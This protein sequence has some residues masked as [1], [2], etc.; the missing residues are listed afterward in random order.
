MMTE[1]ELD[2]LEEEAAK[3]EYR[4]WPHYRFSL[5]LAEVRELR[6]VLHDAIQDKLNSERVW[7]AGVKAGL[8]AAASKCLDDSFACMGCRTSICAIDP[9]TIL[10]E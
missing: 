8:E 1:E 6:A 4:L 3:Q 9:A 7:R 2:A 5:L 10:P